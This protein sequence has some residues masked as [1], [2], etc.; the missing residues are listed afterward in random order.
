ML[1]RHPHDSSIGGIWVF[2]R[3]LPERIFNNNQ[4]VVTDAQFKKNYLLVFV[5]VQKILIPLICLVPTLVFNE[6]IIASQVH[7]KRFSAM[8]TD[9]HKLGWN[10]HI[11]LPVEH[12]KNS[13]LVVKNFLTARLTALKQSVIALRVKKSLFSK[14]PFSSV[15]TTFLPSVTL[16]FA[17]G[18]LTGAET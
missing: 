5:F 9:G 11:I 3:H 15:L 4:C 10:F 6:F 8:L 17:T 12:F 2:S 18:I 16:I 7:C 13:S 14:Q 1:G